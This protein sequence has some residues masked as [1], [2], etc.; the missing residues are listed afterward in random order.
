MLSKLEQTRSDL[1]HVTIFPAFARPFLLFNTVQRATFFPRLARVTLH[2]F[3]G[4]ANAVN[5]LRLEGLKS[6]VAEGEWGGG[7]GLLI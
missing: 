2:I 1:L 7:C 4:Q 3:P 6:E 5:R